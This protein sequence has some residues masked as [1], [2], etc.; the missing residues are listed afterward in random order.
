MEIA[1]TFMVAAPQAEVWAFI[2]SAE[3]VATLSLIH[4]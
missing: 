2:T 4:I 3:K 1:K